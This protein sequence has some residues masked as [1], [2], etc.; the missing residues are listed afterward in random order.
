MLKLSYE[1]FIEEVKAEMYGYEEI[2]EKAI[3]KWFDTLDKFT[4]AKK[5]SSIMSYTNNGIEVN[6][7]DEADLFMIVDRYLAAIV[8][9]DLEKYYTNWSL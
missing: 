5:K 1:D 3:S 2:D 8:N 6:L 7:K 9:E 4:K